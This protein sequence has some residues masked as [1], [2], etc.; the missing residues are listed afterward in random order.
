MATA[1]PAVGVQREVGDFI[2]RHQSAGASSAA[3]NRVAGEVQQQFVRDIGRGV[4]V[5]TAR[6]VAIATLEAFTGT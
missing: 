3:V 2:R 6:A 5:A 4:D 1:Q